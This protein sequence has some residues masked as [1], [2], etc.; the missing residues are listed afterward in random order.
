MNKRRR[1]H[2]PF[3]FLYPA[4]ARQWKAYLGLL[5]GMLADV[6]LTFAFAWFLGNMTD[7]AVAGDWN[8]MKSLLPLGAGLIVVSIA[9]AYGQEYM[10]TAAVE[11][12]KK[13]FKSR[14]HRHIMLLP[15]DSFAKQPSGQ[16]LSHF[17]HD[18]D[19]MDGVLGSSLMRLIK[20]PLVTA[21]IFIYLL[22]I[23][24]ELCVLAIVL[25][26]LA[27]LAGGL[28]GWLLRRNGRSIHQLAGQTSSLLS[29]TMWGFLVIRSFAVEGWFHRKY[30]SQNQERYRL[31]LKD[32]KL[33]GWFHAGGDALGTV[34]FVGSLCAGAYFVLDNRLSVGSL[35]TFVNLTN[36]LIY[37]LTG[38]AGLWAGMQRSLS[39]V[40]RLSQCLEM[41]IVSDTFHENR[42]PKPLEQEI[43]F[44]SMTFGY[45]G[46][47]NVFEGLQLRIPAGKMTAIVGPSGAGKS[48]LFSLLQGFYKPH[49]GS[50]LIDGRSIQELSPSQFRSLFAYVSQET[51]LFS[52]SIRDNLLL[53]RPGMT[54]MEM[55]R[56]AA[57]AHIHA[58]VM[59]LP[60]GYDTLIGERGLSLSG[61]QR[62]RLAIARALLKDAPI[63]L[64]DE[65]TSAVDSVTEQQ[66]KEALARIMKHRTTLVIAHRLSTIQHADRIIVMDQGKIVQSGRHEELMK[67]EG[68]Y[69]K[70]YRM[71]S[72]GGEAA[73]DPYFDT[74]IV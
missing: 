25:A 21:G 38:F 65:A 51:F 3:A 15:V 68:L 18:I 12:V 48:T 71:Q 63:L 19:N 56:A 39:A 20:L 32:A 41:P 29:E 9:A 52:G 74:R 22:R 13:E 2:R 40:E 30:E 33:R 55:M 46:E 59:S 14:L 28:F 69:R 54:E 35:L 70:L 62:Q 73:G 27:V 11:G 5:L 53:A 23:S 72:Q 49:E 42:V 58:F 34:V 10:D 67:Q 31:E 61:G 8:Q 45:E 7:A 17:T 26:P 4:M 66:L 36:H 37:P 47:R 57:A 16:L 50:I 60:E 6:A 44:R 24:W 43:E 1:K 64:L